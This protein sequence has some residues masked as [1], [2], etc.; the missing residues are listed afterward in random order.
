MV[1]SYHRIFLIIVRLRHSTQGKYN[2]YFQFLIPI[3]RFKKKK[4]KM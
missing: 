2:D 4:E 1:T 3:L